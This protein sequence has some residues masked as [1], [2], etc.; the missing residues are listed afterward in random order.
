MSGVILSGFYVR[1][2]PDFI[3]VSAV[4]WQ[5]ILGAPEFYSVLHD[6]KSFTC[7]IDLKFV[8]EQL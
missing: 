3:V 5:H 2:C 1:L 8:P 6:F 7:R 4:E